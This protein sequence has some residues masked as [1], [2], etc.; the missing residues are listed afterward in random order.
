MNNL[1]GVSV[2]VMEKGYTEEKHDYCCL[3]CDKRVAKGVIYPVG[4]V[5]YEDWR[6]MEHHIEEAHGSIFEHLLSGGRENTG[7]SDQ[8]TKLLL[9]I[10]AGKSD[11][12][13]QQELQIGSLS[14]IRNHRFALRKKEKQAKTL[15]AVMNLLRQQ[16]L[17]SIEPVNNKPIGKSFEPPAELT[18]YFSEEDGR[19]VSY[20]LKEY[21]K[22]QLV[23]EVAL[24][25]NPKKVYTEKEVN[26]VLVEVYEDYMLLRRELIDRGLLTRNSEGSE[27][28]LVSNLEDGEDSEMDFKKEMKL[29]AKEEKPSYGV[30]QIKNLTNG[31]IFVGSTPNFKT[32]NGLKFSLNNGVSTHKDLQ[33]DWNACGKEQFEFIELETVDEKD[34]KGKSKKEILEK[35]LDKWLEELQPFGDSGY[36]GVKKEL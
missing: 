7:L 27:Y 26:K 29:K 12:D 34:W 22:E 2:G 11:K 13:I 36:N 4:E 9:L 6:Y 21:E 8:Q 28:R 31:K 20:Q 3:L 5:L 25:F 23:A 32:L 19:L 24:L 1:E 16:E 35:L 33:A 17:Q 14:T 15:V 30:F 18:R 10:Y